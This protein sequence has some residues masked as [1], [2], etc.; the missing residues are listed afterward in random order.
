MNKKEY[1]IL[2]FGNVL[3]KDEG[4]ALYTSEYIESNYT[5]EPS[6]DFIHGDTIGNNLLTTLMQY[7]RVLVLD[8]IGVQDDPGAIYHLPMAQYRA[9]GAHG[10]SE[11]MGVLECLNLLESRHEVL[12]DVSLLGIVPQAL[13]EGIDLSPALRHSVEAYVLNILKTAEKEGFESS[14][15]EHKVSIIDVI[16]RF[17]K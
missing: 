3:H 17:K 8:V 10:E 6:V 5:F 16:E 4:M 2:S 9:L 15:I 7:K 11:E 1:L 14:E 13:E 12:P